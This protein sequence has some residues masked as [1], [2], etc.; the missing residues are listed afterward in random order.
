VSLDSLQPLMAKKPTGVSRA[1]LVAAWETVGVGPSGTVTFLFTD[2]EGSTPLLARLGSEPYQLVLEQHRGLIRQATRQHGG[3]EFGTEGDGMFF[4]FGAADDAVAACCEAQRAL[5]GHPW[6]SDGAVRVR[7]G[8]HTGQATVTPDEDY[9]GLAVHQAARVMTAAHGGQVLASG[10][11]LA[12]LV[13]HRQAEFE[14]L[15]EFSL[16]GFERATRL[17][18]LCHPGLPSTFPPPRAPSATV[19]NLGAQR[20]SFVGRDEELVTLAELLATASLVTIVGPGGMGKTRLATEAGLRLAGRYPGGRGW[21]LS[22][23]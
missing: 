2:I 21:S 19:H 18:Q 1:R 13:G 14:D 11:V 7:M 17:H 8:L 15:G 10:A 12:G 22:Q 3:A 9:V 6:P 23:A 5:I 16:R 4:A 20:S